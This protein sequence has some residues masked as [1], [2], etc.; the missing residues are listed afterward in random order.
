MR[1]LALD[2]TSPP[3]SLALL[4]A[5]RVVHLGPVQDERPFGE[6]LPGVILEALSAAGRT[7][8]D[9]D[10]FVVGSGPGGLTGLR[11]GIAT[12]QGLA[13]AAGRLLAGVSALEA[14]AV[15]ALDEP[16][17]E[18]SEYVAAWSDA[19]RG[20]VFAQLF[21]RS[22]A[23]DLATVEGPLVASPTDLA[24]RWRALVGDARLCVAGSAAHSTV[25][26]WRAGEP[27]TGIAWV[28]PHALAAVMARLG[29][30]AAARG[31]AG[32]PHALQPLYIRRPDAEVARDRRR[33]AD[34]AVPGQQRP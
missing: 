6:C 28:H 21:R 12:A 19:R 5:G 14:T 4:D 25:Q 13:F 17:A 20:E 22:G 24:P 23:H 33:A 8:A 31:V 32:P 2:T 16:V 7:L 15:A 3:G 34:D 9:V 30:R 27:P 29:E 10:L 1:V 18:D 11:V 26:A